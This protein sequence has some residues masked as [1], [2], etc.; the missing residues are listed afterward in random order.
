MT[1][2]APTTEPPASLPAETSDEPTVKELAGK[3]DQILDVLKGGHP[4]AGSE[5]EPAAPEDTAAVVRSELAKLKAK[6][7]AKA[8]T[9]K[10]KADTA[11]RLEKVEK[12]VEKPPREYRKVTRFMRWTGDDDK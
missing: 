2:P 5:S 1:T 10:E 11:A 3:V 7:D 12:A 4:E 6:E 8:R 9:D